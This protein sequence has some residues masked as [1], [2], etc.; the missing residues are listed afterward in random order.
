MNTVKSAPLGGQIAAGISHS[1][2]RLSSRK[3]SLERCQEKHVRKIVKD[4]FAA[5]AWVETRMA[6]GQAVLLH[7]GVEPRQQAFNAMRQALHLSPFDNTQR[8]SQSLAGLV[9]L[10]IRNGFPIP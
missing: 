10:P 8:S 3:A 1:G 9:P 6:C 7:G 5:A 4:P 2:A